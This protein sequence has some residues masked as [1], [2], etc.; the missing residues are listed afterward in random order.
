ME[1]DGL[2]VRLGFAENNSSCVT[3]E[4]SD[5][6]TGSPRISCSCEVCQFFLRSGKNFCG[7]LV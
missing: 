3:D 7:S 5:L 2:A 6:H 4:L 1:G